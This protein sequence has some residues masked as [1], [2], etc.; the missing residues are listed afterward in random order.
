MQYLLVERK[1]SIKRM[2][3]I[4]YFILGFLTCFILFILY[5]KSLPPHLLPIVK[6]REKIIREKPEIKE[7]IKEIIDTVYIEKRIFI[8]KRWT[9]KD[10][11][12]MVQFEAD[13]FRNFYYE[14]YLREKVIQYP[15]IKH[16]EKRGG[17]FILSNFDRGI[18]GLNYKSIGLGIE[19]D[20]RGKKF[21]PLGGFYINF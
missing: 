10:T 6:V 9:F 12:L 19:Y 2:I 13:T 1:Y 15:I 17:I 4:L 20:Y 3:R 5:N 18:L 8:W 11:I 14:I 21:M 16:K 7:F